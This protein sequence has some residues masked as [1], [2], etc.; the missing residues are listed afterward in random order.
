[1][2]CSSDIT[3]NDQQQPENQR[4]TLEIYNNPNKETNTPPKI[5]NVRRIEDQSIFLTEAKDNS[6]SLDNTLLDI[7]KENNEI[8][9][10]FKN[11]DKNKI[12]GIE[13]KNLSQY[14][15]YPKKDKVDSTISNQ[16]LMTFENKINPF[17][18]D[19]INNKKEIQQLKSK[20]K[21]IENGYKN[22]INIKPTPPTFHLNLTQ[23]IEGG[24]DFKFKLKNIITNNEVNFVFNK[25]K[26]PLLFILLKHDFTSSINKIKEITKYEN[27]KENFKLFLIIKEKEVQNVI[28]SLKINNLNDCFIYPDSNSNLIKIFGIDNDYDSKC[29]FININS[30]ISLI[31]E[32]DIEFLTNEF[33]DFYLGRN[34]E[35]KFENFDVEKKYKLKKD[36]FE[37][38]EF[39]NDL[40][41]LKQEFNLE[42][43]FRQIK[44]DKYPV[45]IRFKYYDE[46]K[47][48]AQNVIENLK[49]ILKSRSEIKNYFIMNKVLKNE[50][51]KINDYDNNSNELC[52]I[53][54][55]NDE[56]EKQLKKST[57]ELNYTK[58]AKKDLEK[59]LEE[60]NKI[61]ENLNQE[62]SKRTI[63]TIKK[64]GDENSYL[65]ILCDITDKF[66]ILKKK[67]FKK[68][69][70]YEGN[71]VFKYKNT[72]LEDSITLNHY[73]IRNCDEIILFNN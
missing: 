13:L 34:S 67:Y 3:E 39:K 10:T 69:P 12:E 41:K 52:K 23:K 40:K 58:I 43:E 42:I 68:Y 51:Q 11:T 60:K 55:K 32:N 38:E 28:D 36:I 14:Y 33:I 54:N 48:A 61:I 22:N 49:K 8:F 57:E 59:E 63:V 56:L 31:L 7:E 19:K 9:T 35:K 4:Q 46:D 27:G 70:Q 62:L 47:D 17:K 72:I 30:E 73:K 26:V 5:R 6:E 1:M 18:E 66:E 25:F 16:I 44:N 65:P 21:D 45:N 71:A 64:Y 50:K 20:I 2:G 53:T 29:I 15:I 24:Y 37:K